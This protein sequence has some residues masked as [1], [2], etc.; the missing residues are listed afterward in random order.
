MNSIDGATLAHK[1]NYWLTTL[2]SIVFIAIGFSIPLS[3]AAISITFVLLFAL[4]LLDRNFC[5]K[6]QQVCQNPV[7]VAVAAFFMLHLAGQYWSE[8]PEPI[9]G[10][11]SWMVFLIPVL[12]TA[13]DPKTARLGIYAFV[14]AMMIAESWV[15]LNILSNWE[16]YINLQ[17]FT[18]LV[19]GRFFISGDRISYNPMLA[20][21]IALLLTTLL[22]GYYKG[23]RFFVAIGFLLTMIAN[24][25]M[26]EGRAGHVAFIFVWVVL[27]IY[28]LRNRKVALLGMLG[29]AVVIVLLAFNYSPVFKARILQAQ[30]DLINY[31]QDVMIKDEDLSGPNSLGTRLVFTET[32]LREYVNRPWLGYGTGSFTYAYAKQVE[33]H[34]EKLVLT[35]NPHNYHALILLQFGLLGFV[36]YG[37]IYVTQ[38]KQVRLMPVAYDYRAL[39]LLLPMF[40]LLINMYDTYLWGHQ[41]QALFAYMTAIFYRRDMWESV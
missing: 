26:T 11:K 17:P 10:F 7:F 36:V 23:W 15:Y 40:Y 38:L 29:S 14:V 27:S 16:A 5:A 21:A 8:A 33:K 35:D 31:R 9:D 41:L 4:W 2:R 30:N 34:P 25:F 39:A 6:L 24:M 12:A 13:V 18:P 32:T 22:S 37:A 1:E 20:F 3:T 19:D 28:F